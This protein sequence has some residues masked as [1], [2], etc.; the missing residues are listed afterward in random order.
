[1]RSESADPLDRLLKQA[2]THKD[3]LI[4]QWGRK[5]LAGDDRGKPKARKPGREKA[6]QAARRRRR[7]VKAKPP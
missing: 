3:V 1:V 7:A 2:A 5:L 6:A 4:Q